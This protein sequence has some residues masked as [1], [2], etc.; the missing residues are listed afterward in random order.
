LAS[1]L[2]ATVSGTA[3]GTVDYTFYCNRSDSGTNITEGYAARYVGASETSKSAACSYSNAGTYTGKVI[4]V[5]G[6][7]SAEKRVIV[8][9]SSSSSTQCALAQ[10]SGSDKKGMK[11]TWTN[12][13]TFTSGSAGRIKKVQI[14]AGNNGGA[15]RSITCKVT[16]GS[17]ST[18]V[19]PELKTEAF[20]S[21]SGAAWRTIDLGSAAVDLQANTPY[22]LYCKG[23]DTWDSV[24][25]ISDK[26]KGFTYRIDSCP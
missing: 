5:R 14:K 26:T 1:N 16:D 11:N 25:W 23:P 10:E 12:F 13:A 22:R 6:G 17:G 2:T 18:N 15:W 20:R 24:Y 8:N 19:S 7:V 9:V 4:A 3:Q 21:D